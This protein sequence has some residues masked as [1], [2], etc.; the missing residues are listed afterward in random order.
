MKRSTLLFFLFLGSNLLAQTAF[1]NRNLTFTPDTACRGGDVL[2]RIVN[3]NF[4]K[5]NEYFGSFAEGYTLPGYQLQPTVAVLTNRNLS[6]EAG[7]SVLQ[8]G[9]E[10]RYSDIAPYLSVAWQATPHILLRMGN[11]DGAMAHH[12]PDAIFADERQIT[13][14]PEMGVQMRA[15]TQKLRGEVWI[16]WQQFI[17]RGDTIPEKLT[18]G[19]SAAYNFTP[20]AALQ[21]KFEA[22]MLFSHIG[23]QISNYPERMQTHGN[24]LLK[25][26]L[27]RC[28]AESYVSDWGVGVSAFFYKTFAGEG[29]LPF[30]SGWACSPAA[31]INAKHFDA[32]LTYFRSHNF[33]ALMGNPLFSCL[34]DREPAHYQEDRSLLT[35]AANYHYAIAPCARFALG[36]KLY[37]DTQ[38]R[39]LDYLYALYLT[40]TPQIRLGNVKGRM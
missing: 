19:F 3:Q 14:L 40:L 32:E 31:W 17:R 35:A 22:A 38:A 26:S 34:A 5:N 12:L 8:Y 24:G 37:Y 2:L 18:G 9:G 10:N 30:S 25:L 20:S 27:N 6:L 29:V 21:P 33:Y 13:H 4:F 39:H 36:A 16:D 1:T 15:L 28:Y 7:L 11:L 23:G